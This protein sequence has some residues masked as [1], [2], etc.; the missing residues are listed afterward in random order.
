MYQ[1]D[2]QSTPGHFDLLLCKDE[3]LLK[4]HLSVERSVQHDSMN[5]LFG[6]DPITSARAGT[7]AVHNTAPIQRSLELKLSM[8]AHRLLLYLQTPE[9]LQKTNGKVRLRVECLVTE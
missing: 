8:K 6:I 2:T 9:M 3:P 5:A 1:A 7:K 4:S